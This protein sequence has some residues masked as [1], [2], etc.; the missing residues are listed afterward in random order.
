MQR[1][2]TENSK[3]IFPEKQTDPGNIYIAHRH[4]NVE[5]GTVAEQFRFLGIHKWDFRCSACYNKKSISVTF[6][7][8][9][10][11]TIVRVRVR[12]PIHPTPDPLLKI[13][14]V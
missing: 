10:I 13:L 3:Q 14:K 1:H 9:C 11:V 6:A 2:N 8:I 4:M 12:G 7:L 5:I